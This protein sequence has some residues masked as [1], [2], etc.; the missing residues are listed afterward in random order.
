MVLTSKENSVKFKTSVLRKL[1]RQRKKRERE[2]ARFQCFSKIRCSKEME[3]VLKIKQKSLTWIHLIAPREY[4]INKQEGR[5]LEVCSRENKQLSAAYGNVG[6]TLREQMF[7]ILKFKTDERDPRRTTVSYL[8]V[9]FTIT[10]NLR[11]ST[12]EKSFPWLTILEGPVY[13]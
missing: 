1:I 2:R 10:N 4:R 7:G 11:T 9:S 12:C 3:M 13:G 6:V 8:S 5:S